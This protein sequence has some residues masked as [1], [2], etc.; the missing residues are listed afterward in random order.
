MNEYTLSVSANISNKIRIV[1]KPLHSP[2]PYY[3]TLSAP[4][5]FAFG[6]MIDVGAADAL[7]KSGREGL[8]L[9]IFYGL[10]H[11]EEITKSTTA[12]TYQRFFRIQFVHFS[13]MKSV[14]ENSTESATFNC[15]RFMVE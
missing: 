6:Q 10:L 15:M 5:Q 3:S 11:F 7:Y 9:I 1:E 13:R 2:P 14:R 4:D 8:L 12:W